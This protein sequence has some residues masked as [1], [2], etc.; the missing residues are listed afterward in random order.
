M[1]VVPVTATSFFAHSSDRTILRVVADSWSA[2]RDG[3]GGAVYADYAWYYPS[4]NV[5]RTG[6]THGVYRHF[7][8]F[9][10]SGIPDTATVDSATLTVR[11][12][13]LYGATTIGLYSS[14]AASATVLVAGDFSKFGSTLYSSSDVSA[15]GNI[16]FALN[17]AGLAAISKTGYTKFCL[18]EYTHDGLNVAPADG[19]DVGAVFY[20][21]PQPSFAVSYEYCVPGT[22][23]E[24]AV[25]A[26]S[27]SERGASAAT[28]TERAPA[29]A[30]WTQR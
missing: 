2:V 11:V 1:P 6:S 9:D 18:R 28:W 3:A 27:W 12:S 21:S 29:S 24:R 30:S 8:S 14:L 23:Y 25:G 7:C 15:T 19:E 4:V 13:K 5:W 22:F 16:S 10:T 20:A 17:A 26:G